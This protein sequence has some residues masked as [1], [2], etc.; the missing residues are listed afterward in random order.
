MDNNVEQV[1]EKLVLINTLITGYDAAT[2]DMAKMRYLYEVSRRA[3]S[4]HDTVTKA[5]K[6]FKE[7]REQRNDALEVLEYFTGFED[8]SDARK[9][10]Q[11]ALSAFNYL[12]DLQ[13]QRI[14]REAVVDIIVRSDT[15]LEDE[16]FDLDK[17]EKVI[18]DLTR[19]IEAAEARTYEILGE[20][21]SPKFDEL[22]P[23]LVEGS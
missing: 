5:G 20:T 21:N 14:N 12:G 15:A 19:Q 22:S 8:V 17:Q 9:F 23:I 2:E 13:E 11:R 6:K 4:S 16:D 18:A 3:D 1:R 10:Y 7:L